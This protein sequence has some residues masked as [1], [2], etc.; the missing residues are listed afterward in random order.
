MVGIQLGDHIIVCENEYYSMKLHGE[1]VD[2]VN[3][4]DSLNQFAQ[5]LI[6]R[7]NDVKR[8]KRPRD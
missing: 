2:P 1:I 5:N 8:L 4:N 6:R 7:E 3:L